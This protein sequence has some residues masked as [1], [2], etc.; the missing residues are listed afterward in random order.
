MT[1]LCHP[2]LFKS[3]PLCLLN[4]TVNQVMALSRKYPHL[5]VLHDHMFSLQPR[6]QDEQAAESFGDTFISEE[7]EEAPT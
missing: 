7:G 6:A 3:M 5:C 2:G 1:D 4:D